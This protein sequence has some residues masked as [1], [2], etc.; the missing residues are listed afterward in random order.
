MCRDIDIMFN[1]VLAHIISFVFA[2]YLVYASSFLTHT[3]A[4]TVS[5][6]S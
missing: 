1:S 4:C 5:I 6:A 3:G 2:C